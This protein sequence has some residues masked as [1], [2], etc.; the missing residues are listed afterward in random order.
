MV[1]QGSL[2]KRG[3]TDADL[4]RSLDISEA[5]LNN[6]KHAHPEFMESI[7][8]GREDADAHVANSLYHKALGY[9]HKVVKVISTKDGEII[10]HEYEERIPPDTASAIYWLNNRRR[11]QWRN[12]PAVAVAV[13]ANGDNVSVNMQPTEL[14]QGY[15]S[16][17]EGE[18]E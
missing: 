15:M 12:T 2:R 3:C 17:I 13:Q 18:S 11:G 1:S 9:K 5:T 4:A 6:W 10:E 16:L 14:S 7:K 8:S